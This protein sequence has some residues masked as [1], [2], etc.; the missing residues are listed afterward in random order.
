MVGKRE[1]ED[2]AGNNKIMCTAFDLFY[3]L[4]EGCIAA[5]ISFTG[6][7]DASRL[8]AVSK[9]FK[10]AA[11]SDAV[12]TCFLPHDYQ[13]ILARSSH[14]GNG[15]SLLD[16]LTKK[17]LFF[18][19]ANHPLLIDN[20]TKSF[21]LDKPTGKKCFTISARELAITWGDTPRYWAFH[22]SPESRF[23]EVAELH[24]VCWLEIKGKIKSAMLSP[25]TTYIAYFVFKMTDAAYGFYSPAKVSV[26]TQGNKSES[27]K[28][29]LQYEEGR[30]QRYQIIPRRM[31]L[32]NRIR[33]PF[34]EV[35]A[36]AKRE[37]NKMVL[38]ERMDGWLEVAMGEVTTQVGEDS[39]V[40]MSVLE[41]EGGNWKSGLIVEG[42]EIRPK[43]VSE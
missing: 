17:D 10:S 35:P 22:P 40:E 14:A 4:P 26:K 38:K 20:S 30:N 29:Y 24:S 8:S 18:H 43:A 34:F 42:I 31:S 7:R 32:F 9:I 36:A 33:S 25:N 6:P 12:W 13:Q 16:S 21:F 41:V 23:P 2:Q 15:I 27:R 37:E 11:D 28:V 5:A 1:E 39:E 19:L 3:V